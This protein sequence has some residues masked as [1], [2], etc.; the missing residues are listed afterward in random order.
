MAVHFAGQ[1]VHLVKDDQTEAIAQ[2]FH[3]H[4]G[5]VVSGYR[6]ILDF[7]ITAAEQADVNRKGFAQQ[8][9]PLVH[10]VDGRSNDKRAALDF[11]HG[12]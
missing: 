12:H 1:V 8:I 10:Q 11:E 2:A 7:V 5:A 4:I 3:M 6:H 9:I